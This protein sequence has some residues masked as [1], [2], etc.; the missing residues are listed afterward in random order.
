[1]NTSL[2]ELRLT[3]GRKMAYAEYGLRSGKPLLMLHGTPGG[4]LQA[5]IFDQAARDSGV[6]VIA[7]D[8]PGMGRSD[9]V[10]HLTYLGYADDIRQLLEHLALPR[11]AMAAI[12]GGG[13]FALACAHALRGRVSQLVLVCAAVPVPRESRAGLSVQNRLL[14]WLCRHQPRLA[15][16]LMRLAFP[17]R[18]DAAAVTRIARS[19]PPAD[20]RVMQIPAV[21]DAFLGESTRDMLRQGFAAI[22]HEM[23]LHEGTLGFDLGEI[24]VPVDLLHGLY[25]SNVPP[26]VA[27]Y[28][29]AQ[30]PGARLD[31]IAN[32]AHL[33]ILE[34][35]ERLFRLIQAPT[36][37]AGAR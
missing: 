35:P 18:L 32:A 26:G 4:R 20:R 25:D 16:A 30:I 9:P 28:V 1:M 11:A 24:D 19:M 5:Q 2:L 23:R 33:F 7:T 21:R 14:G 10:P 13:G 22:V 17:R 15:E 3:D 6:R 29:A 8:R 12:S 36:P 34:T 37:G 27:R 31:L